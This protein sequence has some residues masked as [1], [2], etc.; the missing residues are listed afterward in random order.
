MKATQ[1]C[2]LFLLILLLCPLAAQAGTLGPALSYNELA[3]SGAAGARWR[4]AACLRR[5]ERNRRSACHPRLAGN[6]G[7]RQS[8]TAPSLHVSDSSIVFSNLSLLDSFTVDGVSNIELRTVR[9]EGASGQ[10]GL[11]F[12][13]G[14]TLLIDED[15]SVAGGTGATGVSISQRGGDLY[16]SIEG[17]VRGGADGGSGMEVSPMT[18]Y[19]TMMLAGSICGGDG[20]TMGGTGLNLFD[21]SG[22]AFIT[23]AGSVRGGKGS[24]GGAGM[25]VVS[26]GDT[27]SIGVNGEIR[28]GSGA[29]YGGDALI[30]DG[31]DSGFF[32]QSE[33][34][35]DWRQR[36]LARRRTG[37]VASG[38]RG[39]RF[40]CAGGQLPASGRRKY[41]LL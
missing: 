18:E 2:A 34:L 21:L 25:Q 23:V 35:A 31:R 22:N 20:T 7:R 8:D 29:E 13:G 41:V 33:R 9:V 37:A 24:V 6:H 1:A 26:I 17:S 28:G 3:G 39:Q 5:F 32:R 27:V 16:V 30:L 36:L 19:G 15:S 14:G 40:P 10:Y 11:S 12:V 4:R 38:R